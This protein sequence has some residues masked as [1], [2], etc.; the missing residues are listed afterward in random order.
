MKVIGFHCCLSDM[1]WWK[2]CRLV[3][4]EASVRQRVQSQR[5]GVLLGPQTEVLDAGGLAV[6]AAEAPR[7]RGLQQRA[8]PHLLGVVGQGLV[9]GLAG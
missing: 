3:Y 5:S 2:M 6:V 8:V 7:R 1:L 4:S 9:V